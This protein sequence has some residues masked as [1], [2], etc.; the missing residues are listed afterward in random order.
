M[1][2]TDLPSEQEYLPVFQ[3]PTRAITDI[4][5]R[6]DVHKQWLHHGHINVW[7]PGVKA[8]TVY[9]QIKAKSHGKA[10]AT[11]GGHIDAVRENF[12]EIMWRD[13]SELGPRTAV[14]EWREETW[15]IFSEK[16]IIPL[17][18][19]SE[20]WEHPHPESKSWNNGIV[21]V[22]LLHRRVALEEILSNTER[23]EGL[24][25]KEVNIEKLLWLTQND[26]SEYLWK[27]LNEEYKGIFLRLKEALKQL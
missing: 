3:P 13:I 20:T 24:D 15:I 9:K 11:I 6:K 14:K 22:Y 10:D 1:R 4:V 8:G 12:W 16:E 18:E 17:W 23:E 5:N 7:I 19:I 26:R 27:L 21:L 2:H 25:F